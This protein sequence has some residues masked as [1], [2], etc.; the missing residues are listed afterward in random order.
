MKRNQLLRVVVAAL[1]ICLM[2]VLILS[3]C[4]GNTSAP[5]TIKDKEVETVTTEN[6]IFVSEKVTT[7]EVVGTEE[8]NENVTKT[9]DTQGVVDAQTIDETVETTDDINDV[10]TTDEKTEL[11]ET[12]VETTVEDTIEE[13]SEE[14][15]L[16]TLTD[17]VET[18]VETTIETTTE[19][20]TTEET[21]IEETEPV[22]YCTLTFELYFPALKNIPSETRVLDYQVPIGSDYEITMP[23]KTGYHLVVKSY[24]GTATEDIVTKVNYRTDDYAVIAH[25]VFKDGSQVRSDIVN[26]YKFNDEYTVYAWNWPDYVPDKDSYTGVIDENTKPITV[27]TFVYTHE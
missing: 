21:T 6:D 7:T 1:A 10:T 12:T 13:T 27:I 20:A 2:S 3:S 19:E 14:T 15:V 4:G 26:F 24:K 16:T 9:E 22:R 25:F 5:E 23:E 8:S 18:T 11:I 17:P